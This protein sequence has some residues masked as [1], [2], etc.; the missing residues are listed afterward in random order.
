VF[1]LRLFLVS[2]AVILTALAARAEERITEF[3]ADITVQTNGNIQVVETIAVISEGNAIQ[4]G[5]Y[6]DFPRYLMDGRHKIE[7]DV[8]LISVTRNG[9]PEAFTQTTDG[10][11][12]RWRLGSA[13]RFLERGPHKYVLTYSVAN[14]IRYQ[15]GTDEFYW[16]VTGSHWKFPIDSASASVTFPDGVVFTDTS[17][18]TGRLGSTEQ[19]VTFSKSRN[20]V[21]AKT[22][23]PLRAREN[24]SVS[25]SINKGLIDP[26]SASE[27]SALWWIKNGLLTLLSGSFLAITAFYSHA[28][29]KVGRDPAKGPVF[30]RYAPPEGYSPA[31]VGY[32]YKRHANTQ[33]LIAAMMS[34]ATRGEMEIDANKKTTV[35]SRTGNQQ[36]TAFED[37]ALLYA[38]LFPRRENQ[39]TL[40]GKYNSRFTSAKRIFDNYMRKKFGKAYYKPN[41]GY[42]IAGFAL[43]ILSAIIA[44]NMFGSGVTAPAFIVL[45]L[46]IALNLLFA[47]LMPAPTKKGQKIR[48]QIEGFRLY[49]KT[50]EADRINTADIEG[51]RPPAM[52]TELYERFMPYAV[53]LNVEKPW[54]KYFEKALPIEAKNYQPRG[55][56]GDFINAGSLSR[57]AGRMVDNI[58]SSASSAM[59]QSRSSSGSGGGGFSGGG[60]G[61]G[62]GGGW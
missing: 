46:L 9:T 35:L 15:A 42:V 59:P 38:S 1:K 4:R 2:L 39:L 53:A 55:L 29:N 58:S 36:S 62:G 44:F 18:Y 32:I 40:A 28:W 8:K 37:E 43:S 54:T 41:A 17:G 10:N 47:F 51:K 12:L 7:Q 31:A 49:L 23:R 26:P 50:A 61:G 22:D 11:A 5:I 45:G 14:Q 33:A 34:M 27:R 57:A 13:N 56:R 20:Q 24:L 30:P 19:A 52:T 6:R 25:I 60:G 21:K 3:N 48:T 16:N